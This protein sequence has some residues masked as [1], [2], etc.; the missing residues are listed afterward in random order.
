M[1][2]NVI[3]NLQTMFLDFFPVEKSLNQYKK[4]HK[5]HIDLYIKIYIVLSFI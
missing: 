3:K 2:W 5:R 1:A 4:M